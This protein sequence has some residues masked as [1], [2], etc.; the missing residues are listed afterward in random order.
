MSDVKYLSKAARR[1]LFDRTRFRQSFGF[2]EEE[3]RI[4]ERNRGTDV[5]IFKNIDELVP[6]LNCGDDRQA[7]AEVVDGLRR[8]AEAGNAWDRCDHP[9][10][11]GAE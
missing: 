6:V 9:D 4:A 3:I 10:V 8:N 11:A 1:A 2:R 5:V 7:C